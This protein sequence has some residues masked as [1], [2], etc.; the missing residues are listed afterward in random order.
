M[1]SIYKKLKG[2]AHQ[3]ARLVCGHHD[4]DLFE[5]IMSDSDDMRQAMFLM[6]IM[7]EFS[8]KQRQILL[9]GLAREYV[10]CDGWLDYVEQET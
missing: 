7:K 6:M 9:D 2:K 3:I 10:G 8:E 1:T 4:G 5:L